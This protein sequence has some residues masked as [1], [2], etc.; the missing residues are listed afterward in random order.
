MD[1]DTS[2]PLGQQQART[3]W[4]THVSGAAFDRKKTPYLTEQAQA[5]IAQQMFC[6]LAGLG[7]HHEPSGLL[8]LGKPGFVQTL[9]RHTC[10]LQLDHR[11]GTSPLLRRLRQSLPAGGVA[12]LGL[13][14][15]SHSTR[16][17]LC[18][19]GTAELVPGDSP[20][21]V[22]LFAPPQ[23]T[24]VGLHVR[25]AFFHCAKY[26]RTHIAGLTA[27]VAVSS[28]QPWQPQQL[29]GSG[30]HALTAAMQAFIREQVLCFLCTMNQEGQ[31]AVNH[32][33]GTP[34]FLLPL[35]PD[36]AAPGGTVVLPDYA[37]NGAFEAIGNILETGQA[38]LVIPNYAA[39]LAVCLSGSARIVELG[40][41]APELV[42][43]CRGA[44]RVVALSVR[45][46]ETQSGD[47]SAALGYE[48]VRAETVKTTSNAAVTCLISSSLQKR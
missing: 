25:Q 11:M 43:R 5:F 44:E 17:R 14:F 15:I 35:P 27:P 42:Q 1:E 21:L 20:A 48:R 40:E 19:Q 39:Q 47:W 6:V 26:I 46:V 13:F 30:Q 2:L 37:G 18:V 16:E 29:L 41:L 31:Y 3:R 23:Q 8:A 9:D 34:G 38:A 28:E 22:R 36:E 7:P 10:L 12:Q 24:L 45:Q 33:G 4:G 32:R